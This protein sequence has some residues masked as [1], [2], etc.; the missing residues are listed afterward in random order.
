MS[1][2]IISTCS[3]LT[4]ESVL[5]N[6]TL[7]VIRMVWYLSQLIKK[8]VDF[9]VLEFHYYI[10]NIIANRL[11]Q[12]N[13]TLTASVVWWSRVLGYRSGGPG[14]IP[15]TTK[16]KSSGSGTGSTQTREYNWGAT[17]KKSSG[18]CLE[19]REYGRR[20]LSR[21]SHGT[22]CLQKLAITSPTSGSRS[23]GIV[24]SWTQTMVFFFN[25]TLLL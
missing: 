19:N 23:V 8:C 11:N 4:S 6:Y 22:L 20:D 14:S 7:T 13:N 2:N 15:G 16:K 21:W 18:S 1:R 3:N 24:H 10:C 25:N 17:W 5:Q 9:V 12:V